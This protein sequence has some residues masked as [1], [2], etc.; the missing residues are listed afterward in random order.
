MLWSLRDI[1]STSSWK[2]KLDNLGAKIKK[3]RF[4][5]SELLEKNKEAMVDLVFQYLQ[6]WKFC[7]TP[8]VVAGF[9]FT[10]LGKIHWNTFLEGGIHCANYEIYVGMFSLTGRVQFSSSC[11]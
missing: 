10:Q 8:E 3:Y 5:Y 9:S 2:I 7:S 4:L 11:L 6:S 1:I